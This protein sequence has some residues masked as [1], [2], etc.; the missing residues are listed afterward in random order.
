MVSSGG[1]EF[2]ARMEAFLIRAATIGAAE[3][4][5]SKLQNGS[6]RAGHCYC[7]HDHT[8]ISAS[9]FGYPFFV[10]AAPCR[11]IASN[12]VGLSQNRVSLDGS[13]HDTPVPS[14]G[15]TKLAR[16]SAESA[17]LPAKHATLPGRDDPLRR[18]AGGLSETPTCSGAGA[19]SVRQGLG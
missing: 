2:P 3:K 14:E 13:I 11:N 5:E 12:R 17:G 19:S 8:P 1:R 9:C 15:S 10:I 16:S 4:N 6:H 18:D 7:P